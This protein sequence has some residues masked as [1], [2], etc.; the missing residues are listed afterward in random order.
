M[1]AGGAGP[2]REEYFSSEDF[3]V[4]LKIKNFSVYDIKIT[5]M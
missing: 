1:P 3:K 4:Y 2:P 5:K